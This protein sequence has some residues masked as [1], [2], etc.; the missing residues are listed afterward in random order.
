MT[1]NDDTNIGFADL[2]LPDPIFRATN[3]LGFDSCTEVQRKVLPYSLSEYDISAQA[4][5]GTGKTAAFLT[6]ILTRHIE[7]PL[8][9]NAKLAAPRALILAPTREL[10]LQI[11]AD[12][13][14]LGKYSKPSVITLV[15]GI[16][17]NK[18]LNELRREPV[19]IIVATPGRLIDFVNRQAVD[20]SSVEILVIDEADRLLDMGFI[21][22]VRRIVRSTPH[23]NQRQTMFF[24][25]TFNDEVLRLAEQWTN[26][27]IHIEV[28]PD[29]IAAKNVEQ[30]FWIVER[31]SK[32]DL[33]VEF[34]SK[35]KPIHT[36]VFVNMRMQVKWLVDRL[37]AEGI[38][39][40]G[41]SGDMP[42]KKR[43]KVLDRF[44]RGHANLLVATDVA[45]RGLHVEGISH[46]VNYELP[47]IANDYVHRIGRTGRVEA[48]GTAI[49]F[50]SERDAFHIHELEQVLGHNISCGYPDH[51]PALVK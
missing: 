16:S 36:L 6:T 22:S 40:D 12:T 25:A 4:Q 17:V 43:L 47:E 44:K 33:L 30:L 48:R 37:R 3:K 46:V 7:N 45:G 21:P 13:H 31:D 39:C 51:E 28:Q 41:L 26:D 19:E 8:T 49:S 23:K 14:S 34:I 27:G 35:Q 24:S 42:Q 15:G 1:L 2:A 9:G 18:Q 20:L 38:A 5:T 32:I 50:V 11:E 29:S 10:A